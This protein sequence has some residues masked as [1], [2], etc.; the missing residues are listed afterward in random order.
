[1][2]SQLI[3]QVIH[4]IQDS[5]FSMSFPSFTS[6]LPTGSP[7]LELEVTALCVGDSSIKA[8]PHVMSLSQQLADQSCTGEK[9]V[10]LVNGCAGENG[11]Q[12]ARA[13]VKKKRSKRLQRLRKR[14]RRRRRRLNSSEDSDLSDGNVCFVLQKCFIS[15]IEYFIR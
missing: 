4:H 3:Q 15:E 9:T 13:I 8:A 10:D 1:M 14:R 11:S 2:L 5:V 12:E 7:S 6:P